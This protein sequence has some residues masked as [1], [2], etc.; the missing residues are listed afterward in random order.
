MN[1]VARALMV[2][3]AFGM[4][5]TAVTFAETPATAGS[6]VSTATQATMQSRSDDVQN[7]VNLGHIKST[8][9]L[10]NKTILFNM[11]GGKKLVNR[12][13]HTCHGLKFEKRF[14]YKTSLHQLCNVDTI[15]VVTSYGRGAT[16]GLG[17]F[18]K[19]V[20][21]EKVAVPSADGELKSEGE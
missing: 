8:R 7:C 4:S 6:P 9:V 1:I 11:N 14:G 5:A 17:M 18:E 2:C 20:E 21:P 13:P 3:T 10:D 12:L 15:F 19:Y 16:C